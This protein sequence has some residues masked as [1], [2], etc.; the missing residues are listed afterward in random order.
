MLASVQI[1]NKVTTELIGTPIDGENNGDGGGEGGDDDGDDG[2]DGDS[3][4]GDDDGGDDMVVLATMA[5]VIIVTLLAVMETIRSRCWR[6]LSMVIP[7]VIWL[8]FLFATSRPEPSPQ[9]SVGHTPGR[10]FSVPFLQ[11]VATSAHVVAA[12]SSSSC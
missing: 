2:T 5:M 12:T 4:H 11:Q 3:D 10:I 8:L 7:I 1:I 9:H 6:R